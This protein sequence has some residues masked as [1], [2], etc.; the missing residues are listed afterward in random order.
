MGR[1]DPVDPFDYRG[2]V[3]PP[4]D[5]QGFDEFGQP[6]VKPKLPKG[7]FIPGSRNPF[8][9]HPPGFGGGFGGGL[10][11]GFGQNNFFWAEYVNWWIS[12]EANDYLVYL[13]FWLIISWRN[14]CIKIDQND[15]KYFWS[16]RLVSSPNVIYNNSVLF[17]KG[18]H[19]TIRTS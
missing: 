19:E 8:D 3:E 15:E 13:S 18:I 16:A 11:G 2:R 7:P 4:D 9:Q 17:I 6:I 5:F 1:Y 12:I 10:G 14:Y